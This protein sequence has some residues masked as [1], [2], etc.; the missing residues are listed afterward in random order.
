MGAGPMTD[1]EVAAAMGGP[2]LSDADVAR[3]MKE[4]AAED[5]GIGARLKRGLHNIASTVKG[6]AKAVGEVA[7]D[8]RNVPENFVSAVKEPGRFLRGDFAEPAARRRQLEPGI[9][10]MVT[11]V[12]GQR[13]A[14]RI[15]NA[16]GDSPETAIGPETFGSVKPGEAFAGPGAPVP[17]TQAADQEAA[18]EFRQLG[19]LVGVGLPGA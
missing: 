5:N 3:M 16:A 7:S 14:A 8:I 13:L 10:D 18:P 15:G 11:L 17:N 9:D 12:Y 4:P 19:N 2:A 6:G 1:A